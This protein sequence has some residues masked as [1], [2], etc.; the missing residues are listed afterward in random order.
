MLA[1][2]C[3]KAVSASNLGHTGSGECV[4]DRFNLSG[5]D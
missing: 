2:N 5:F 4:A 1:K 3:L